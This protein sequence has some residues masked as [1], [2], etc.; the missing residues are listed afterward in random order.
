MSRYETTCSGCGHS[1]A[2]DTAR[3]TVSARYKANGL[4]GSKHV[5]AGLATAELT[6]DDDLVVWDCPMCDYSD[7]YEEDN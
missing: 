5:P 3:G 1:L 2:L 6:F 4:R 7:S